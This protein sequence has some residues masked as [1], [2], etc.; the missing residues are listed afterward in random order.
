MKLR[1]LLSNIHY[2]DLTEEQLLDLEVKIVCPSSTGQ[3]TVNCG[4]KSITI[5]QE[6]RFG[7]T[8]RKMIPAEK[9]G[10]PYI[11]LETTMVP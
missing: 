11:F 8:Q 3:Y 2:G 1:E 6:M 7:E 4:I 9:N 10:L 5:K